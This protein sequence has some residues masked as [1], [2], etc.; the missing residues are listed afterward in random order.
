M[1]HEE[2]KEI[3]CKPGDERALLSYAFKN[4]DNFYSICSKL[5]E[6]DFLYPEHRAIYTIMRMLADRGGLEK[7]DI[8]MI[9]NEATNNGVLENI[10]RYDYVESIYDMPLEQRNLSYYLGNVLESSTKYRLYKD[11]QASLGR[12]EQNAKSGIASEDLIGMVEAKVMDLSTRAKSLGEPRDLSD[13]LMDYIEEKRHES[14][15]MSGISTGYAILDNQIDGLVPGTLNI[16]TARKKMGKSTFLSNVAANVAYKMKNP[17]LYVDTEMSFGEWRDRIVAMLTN[18]EERVIKHGGYDDETY[19]KIKKGLEVVESGKLFHERMPAYSVD[20]LV[21]LYKKYK[22][23]E[24]ISLGIF[25][26]IKEPDSSS[27]DRQRKEWQIL[28]DVATK[29]KDLSE[30]L[31]IPFVAAVQLNREGDVAGSDRIS[32]F[33]DVLMHW[34]ERSQEETDNNKAHCGEEGGQYKIVIKDTRRG[35]RTP[36]EGIGYIFRKK[37]LLIREAPLNQQLIAYGEG[38][39]NHGTDDEDELE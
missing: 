16:L 18:V 38:V 28:G 23:K 30:D 24:D 22:I 17:V 15:D 7:F 31:D 5:D 19:S 29:L 25:D 34:S 37:R 26:Y 14:V 33:C 13:G 9:V 8:S 4:A 20:K 36:E 27:V 6:K 2:V 3:F 39:V 1:K 12:L 21:A 35:G 10:G 32:W 11:L